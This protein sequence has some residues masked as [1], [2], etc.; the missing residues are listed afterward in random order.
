M[1]THDYGRAIEYFERAARLDGGQIPVFHELSD[2]YLQ[3][4]QND[5]VCTCLLDHPLV[6]HDFHTHAVG[7]CLGRSSARDG[8]GCVQVSR[9]GRIPG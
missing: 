6:D 1:S 5:K 4:K 3:L 9:G 7:T 2:L 8:A